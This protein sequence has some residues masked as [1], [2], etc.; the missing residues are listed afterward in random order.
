M[1]HTETA[2]QFQ[3]AENSLHGV[4]VLPEGEGPFPV[5][6][7]V[8]GSGNADR[9]AKNM[10]RPIF[11][12]FA[13][14][15]IASL[16]WDKPGVGE[17]T[18]H[19]NDQS[20]EDRTEETVTAIEWLRG[21]SEIDSDRIGLWGISQAGWIM[22]A[23][24]EQIT[25][26]AFMIGVSVPVST[27]E[28][29]DLYR[30]EH[31]FLAD[32]FSTEDKEKALGLVRQL[33]QFALEDATFD[34]AMEQLKDYSDQPWARAAYGTPNGAGFEFLK[35][36]IRVDPKPQIRSIKCPVLLILGEKDTLVNIRETSET[37]QQIFSETGNIDLTIKE[38]ANADHVLTLTEAGGQMEILQKFDTGEWEYAPGYIKTMGEWMEDEIALAN[39]RQYSFSRRLAAL[40]P[41]FAR[42]HDEHI[43][44]N[45]QLLA[46]V[47]ME[48]VRV[49][50]CALLLKEDDQSK[51][52]CL[53]NF[54]EE[55]FAKDSEEFESKQ[56]GSIVDLIAVSFIEYLE[57]TRD[58]G[59]EL[60]SMLGPN[61]TAEFERQKN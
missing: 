53:L 22:P 9:Y 19:F 44:F 40:S 28:E 45:G 50:L 61:L 6:V 57:L 12:E 30:I 51:V 47:F 20:F 29:Q 15:G 59:K 38:F 1:T 35:R 55:E 42:L 43:E 21:R 4:L 54:L 39:P 24:C 52:R 13:N 10:Y 16:S 25:D 49:S 56:N 17:S 33:H 2:I 3:S 18:G 7:F 27:V 58:C 8:H 31:T 46:T 41:E 36:I 26:I 37:Y 23:V 32:G 60:V 11:E 14:R 5:A 34:E 48:E